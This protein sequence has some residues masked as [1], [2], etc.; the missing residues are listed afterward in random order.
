[1][2]VLVVDDNRGT[3]NAL[4]LW[5]A[6]LGH[7]AVICTD[8]R[9]GLGLLGQGLQDGDPVRLVLTDQI[10][11]GQT[12]LEFIRACQARFPGIRAILMTAYQDEELKRQALAL[13][14]CGFLAKPFTP[15]DLRRALEE[16]EMADGR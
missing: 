12:G 15:Q 8:P 10:L 5:L 7:K 2:S 14:G 3:L 9:Q 13:P 16:V 6:R 1:M 11:P 4:E